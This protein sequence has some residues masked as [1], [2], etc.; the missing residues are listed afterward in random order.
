MARETIKLSAVIPARPGRVFK[1]WLNAKE[2]GAFT[3]EAAAVEA[4]AGTRHSA[5]GGYIHGWTLAVQPSKRR[6]T[7]S[8][9]TTEFAPGDVD[10][11]VTVTVTRAKGGATVAIV[12]ADVPEGQTER[13][14]K[15][16]EDFYFE[17]LR[18]YFSTLGAKPVRPAKAEKK[19]AKKA[20]KKKAEKPVEKPAK[21]AAKKKA[22]KK[23]APKKKA[24]KKK[25]E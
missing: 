13:Y 15:G 17:R 12:H 21:K 11:T 18:K 16:W 9:R 25:A 3:G 19:A 2:H 4:K 7:Q 20:A 1:A 6:F 24:P 10:S 23:K 5:Y 8:W 14:Q 22:P